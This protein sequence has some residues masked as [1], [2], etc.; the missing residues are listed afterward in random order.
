MLK[1]NNKV[2]TDHIVSSCSQL[3]PY[4]FLER[5]L[6]IMLISFLIKIHEFSHCR[7]EVTSTARPHEI[8]YIDA[9]LYTFPRD[10]GEVKRHGNTRRSGGRV[11]SGIQGQS[12]WWGSEG[13]AP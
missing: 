9:V 8:L 10:W 5:V 1:L 4:L 7:N 3:T 13:E 11:P 6:T 12:P 2:D